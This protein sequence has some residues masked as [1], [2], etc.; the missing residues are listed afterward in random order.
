M[1]VQKI[2]LDTFFFTNQTKKIES[3]PEHQKQKVKC[4]EMF[5]LTVIWKNSYLLLMFKDIC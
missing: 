1:N 4:P 2:I 5:W 3:M